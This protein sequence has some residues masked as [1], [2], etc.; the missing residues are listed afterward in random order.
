MCETITRIVK[1]KL[2][3]VSLS[4]TKVTLINQLAVTNTTKVYLCTINLLYSTSCALNMQ[5]D[6]SEQFCL[7]TLGAFLQFV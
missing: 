4:E 6:Q 1:L 2:L 7:L 3:S 5:F